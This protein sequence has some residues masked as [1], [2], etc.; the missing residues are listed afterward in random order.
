MILNKYSNIREIRIRN[1]ACVKV[2]VDGNWYYVGENS[3]VS[4]ISKGTRLGKDCENI[5]QKACN[6][7]IY[8]YEKSLSNGFFVMD[9]GTRVGVCGSVS[10]LKNSFSSFTSLCFRIPH[11]ISIIKNEDADDICNESFAVIGPPGSGKT[12]F[13]KNFID[14]AEKKS[15]I[16]VVDERGELDTGKNVECDFIKYSSKE[17]ALTIG[18]R[19]LS[20]DWIVCDE[21][22]PTDKD[23]IEKILACGVKV[24][25]SC[26]GYTVDDFYKITSIM[27]E[28]NKF[29]ILNKKSDSYSIVCKNQ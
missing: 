19:A 11:N 6:D 18:V 23:V 14:L 5:I 12:T 17:Y 4:N 27:D 13:L 20:P 28:F 10:G 15:N 29:V 25:C 7:S 2:N 16:L 1:N 26:H 21:L 9:D 3:L 24:A 8:A 22:M